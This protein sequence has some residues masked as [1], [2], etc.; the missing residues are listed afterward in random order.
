MKLFNYLFILLQ[1]LVWKTLD[2]CRL[3]G[4]L[5]K[6]SDYIEN[7][8]VGGDLD[9]HSDQFPVTFYQGGQGKFVKDGCLKCVDCGWSV[10]G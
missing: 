3:C 9:F 4:G 2:R 8:W 5:M 7:T 10:H 1:R 6:T